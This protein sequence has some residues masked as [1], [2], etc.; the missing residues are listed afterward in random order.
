[1]AD[2]LSDAQFYVKIE[3]DHKS[4]DEE[5][6]T[7][8]VATW[9]HVSTAAHIIWNEFNLFADEVRCA[10]KIQGHSYQTPHILSV[11]SIRLV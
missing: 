3:I 5:K 6:N 9:V 1:M 4:R 11:C 7:L 2:R 10:S 8:I